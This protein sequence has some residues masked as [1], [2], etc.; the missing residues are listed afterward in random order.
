MLTS[1]IPFDGEVL[2]HLLYAQVHRLPTPP[3]ARVASLGT[4]VDAV[5]MKGLAKD[6]A[7]R[8]AS[9]TEFVDALESAL[10]APPAEVLAKT[11]VM[12]TSVESTRQLTKRGAPHPPTAETVMLEHEPIASAS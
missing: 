11:M 9:A 1:V 10:S 8:W 2:M 12:A 7:S 6:P 5:L 3:S 4:E